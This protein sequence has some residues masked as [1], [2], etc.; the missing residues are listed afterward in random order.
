MH[1]CDCMCAGRVWGMPKPST[2]SQKCPA[3]HETQL[4]THWTVLERIMA[5][6][7]EHGQNF[8][9]AIQCCVAWVLSY[10][11]SLALISL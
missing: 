1:M 2:S 11:T 10:F 6:T 7:R 3:P 9:Y 4:K 8:I 5:F